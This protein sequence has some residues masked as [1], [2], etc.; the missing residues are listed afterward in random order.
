M[1]ISCDLVNVD[2]YTV[3]NMNCLS[4]SIIVVLFISDVSTI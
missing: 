1:V 4:S 3:G 2:I